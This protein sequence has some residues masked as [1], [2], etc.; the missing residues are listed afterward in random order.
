[1]GSMIAFPPSI[2]LQV[3]ILHCPAL[4]DNIRHLLVVLVFPSAGFLLSSVGFVAASSD[5]K[6]AGVLCISGGSR[7]TLVNSAN[8]Q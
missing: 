1:M 6:P 5:V 3:V 7:G 8:T 4:A 2:P